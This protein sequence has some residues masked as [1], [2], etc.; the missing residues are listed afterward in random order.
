MSCVFCDIL[1]NNQRIIYQ[2]DY[3]FSIYDQYPVNPG[4]ILIITK[5]HV[6][7]YFS[8]TMQEKQAID[9]ALSANK[10]I[11]DEK[12]KPSAYNIGINNGKSAGQTVMHLHVHLIPRFDGDVKDPTGG[13]RG[14]IF[15]KQKY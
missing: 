14:V 10:K 2:N 9:E 12:L 1:E 3:A 6:A 4:H 11:L 15:E 5:R 7:D 13:V 8:L